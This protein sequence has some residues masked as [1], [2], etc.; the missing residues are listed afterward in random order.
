MTNVM[1]PQKLL[2]RRVL[3][4]RHLQILVTVFIVHCKFKEFTV[5]KSFTVLSL[6]KTMSPAELEVPGSWTLGQF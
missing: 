4:L 6:H 1:Y 3:I 5:L 2:G